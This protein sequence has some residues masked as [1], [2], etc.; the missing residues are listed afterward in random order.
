MAAAIAA[1]VL[2]NDRPRPATRAALEAA[3]LISPALLANV[4]VLRIMPDAPDHAMTAALG[5]P[6][7]LVVMGQLWRARPG[8]AGRKL[9]LVM[10]TLAAAPAILSLAVVLFVNNPLLAFDPVMGLPVLNTLALSYAVPGL[11]LLFARARIVWLPVWLQAG[12]MWAGAGFLVVYAGLVIR[13]V[14]QGP[15][16]SL[17]GVTQPEL[18]SYTLAALLLG[19]GLLWQAIARN[20]PVLR[21]AAMVVIGLTAAK[22]FLLDA[23]G[24]SGLIRVFS[25][26][27]LGLSLAGLAW[28]NRWASGR[29]AESGPKPAPPL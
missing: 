27:A 14:W 19:A 2:L 10:A 9:R 20:S 12:L 18:Y 23:A 11:L 26:L 5:L 24:L 3:G 17:P 15:Y 4:L 29:T 6:W 28:L 21:R 7:I 25:F 16:L 1:L 8:M 13:H 22:V